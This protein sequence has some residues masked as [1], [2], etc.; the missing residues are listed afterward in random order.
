MNGLEALKEIKH[1]SCNSLSQLYGTIE[2][3]FETE[4][5]TIERELKVNQILKE[6]KVDLPYIQYLIAIY[7][8]VNSNFL[9]LYNYKEANKLTKEEAT[10]IVDWLKGE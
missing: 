6:K 7:K 5:E 8:E 3:A 1:I 9:I 2:D 4:F 10:L